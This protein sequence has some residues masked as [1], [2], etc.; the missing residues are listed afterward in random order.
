MAQ[1]LI[2]IGDDCMQV[3]G[4]TSRDRTCM[5]AKEPWVGLHDSFIGYEAS[6]SDSM[7][8]PLMHSSSLIV[9]HKDKNALAEF[10]KPRIGKAYS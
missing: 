6:C 10:L 7:L 1:L 8:K 4:L 5:Q 2:R 3:S 9:F